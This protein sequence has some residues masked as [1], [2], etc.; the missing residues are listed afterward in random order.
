ASLQRATL[1]LV[2]APTLCP[3][4]QP[5][6]LAALSLA[7]AGQPSRCPLPLAPFCAR[8]RFFLKTARIRRRTL[9]RE[10]T[11][12]RS[13]PSSPSPLSTPS[14]PS[15]ARPL[16]LRVAAGSAS[17]IALLTL[18]KSWRS[19]AGRPKPSQEACVPWFPELFLQALRWCT[20]P[21]RRKKTQQK[22]AHSPSVQTLLIIRL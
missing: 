7:G 13:T 8:R 16:Q 19:L 21:V 18:G 9:S 17:S 5:T 14:A 2:H 22:V 10:F 12:T 20:G 1:R 6:L 4:P 15:T 3:S 11:R